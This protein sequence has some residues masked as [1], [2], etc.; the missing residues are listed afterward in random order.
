VRQAL[1]CA[2]LADNGAIHFAGGGR[3]STSAQAAPSLSRR[4]RRAGALAQERSRSGSCRLGPP[5]ATT[6]HAR[7]DHGNETTGDVLRVA[8]KFPKELIERVA[9][10]QFA[11]RLDSRVEAFLQLIEIG[12]EA[13]SPGSGPHSSPGPHR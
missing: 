2:L 10:F 13:N 9:G 6:E 5:L 12:L 3:G 7:F 4:P 8:V 1:A 11:R